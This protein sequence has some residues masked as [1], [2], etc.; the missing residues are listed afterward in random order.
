[1]SSFYVTIEP[2]DATQLSTVAAKTEVQET[3]KTKSVDAP[4]K[5]LKIPRHLLGYKWVAPNS[6]FWDAALEVLFRAFA[7]LPQRNRDR[8]ITAAG[9]RGP[10]S[11]VSLDAPPLHR[12]L[13]HFHERLEWILGKGRKYRKQAEGAEVLKHGQDLLRSLIFDRWDLGAHGLYGSAV[14]WTQKLTEVRHFQS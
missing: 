14:Q 2:S 1:M 13:R 8:L 12:V 4:A 6:C 9:I 3:T 7:G 10:V 5:D 11:A